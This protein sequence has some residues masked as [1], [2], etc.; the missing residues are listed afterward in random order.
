M[1][2]SNSTDRFNGVL[3]SKAIKV[4]CV[5]ATIANISLA[6]SQ[7]IDG[8]TVVTDDRVLVKDQTN[9]AEN[10]IYD[11]KANA[12]ERAADWDGNRDITTGTLIG[13][14][15]NSNILSLYE[16]TTTGQ[17]TIGTTLVDIAIF[18]T[19]QSGVTI[20]EGTITNAMLRWDGVD[21]YR[22][23]DR[24]RATPNGA[25]LQIYNAALTE[26]MDV[27]YVGT[28][29]LFTTD[30]SAHIFQFDSEVVLNAVDLQMLGGDIKLLDD[31]E[32]QFGTTA[33][34]DF[35]LKWDGAVLDLS[36]PGTTGRTFRLRDG[37]ILQIM[38]DD[39]SKS[40]V[41][42]IFGDDFVW[43]G[44]AGITNFSMSKLERLKLGLLAQSDQVSL[45][46]LE[47]SDAPSDEADY[48]QF[49][50]RD[51]VNQTP[52]F[53][54]DLGVDYEL[55][56]SSSQIDTFR[57]TF[58]DAV[59]TVDPGAGF[60][61]FNNVTPASAIRLSISSTDL[62]GND[63]DDHMGRI[64]DA[65]IV[66]VVDPET[67]A[68]YV[69]FSF[70]SSFDGGGWWLQN[71]I[72]LDGGL[73]P[74]DGQ[75]VLV[76]ITQKPYMDISSLS[77]QGS[78]MAYDSTNQ[79]FVSSL[80][81]GRL[82]QPQVGD[83]R[84][85][86]SDSVLR[87]ES[88]SRIQMNQSLYVDYISN[89][90]AL[91]MGDDGG[92]YSIGTGSTGAKHLDLWS[93]GGTLSV[94]VKGGSTL[95]IAEVADALADI[96]T[97]GQVWVDSDNKALMYTDEAGND[98][99][100]GGALAAK[101]AT[102]HFN[103]QFN[104]S[105]A[106]ADP[107]SGHFSFNNADP[108]LA[109]FMYISET[110]A[111]GNTIDTDLLDLLITGQIVR[112]Q[113]NSDD[114]NRGEML[115]TGNATDFG[116][117][118]RWGVADLPQSGPF[119]Q[120]ANDQACQL[121]HPHKTFIQEGSIVGNN[122][123]M[124]IWND[125]AWYRSGTTL[126]INPA[127]P[128]S[129]GRI[130]STGSASTDPDRSFLFMDGGNSTSCLWFTT[131][132]TDD[133]G[134]FSSHKGT[135]TE[136]YSWNYK[137]AGAAVRIAYMDENYR[138]TI[139]STAGFFMDEKGADHGNLAN[140]GEFWVLNSAPTA[141]MF[142]SSTGVDHNLLSPA[143]SV[144]A[145]GSPLDNQV[146]VFT[147]A[148]DIDSHSGFTWDETKVIII[149][150]VTQALEVHGTSLQIMCF[151][152]VGSGDAADSFGLNK[153]DD[154][155]FLQATDD[156][157]ASTRGIIN[158]DVTDGTVGVG[159]ADGE[160]T[161]N[162]HTRLGDNFELRLGTGD[163]VVI[164]WDTVDLEIRGAAGDQTINFRDGFHI[165][166]WDAADTDWVDIHNNASAIVLTE[167]GLAGIQFPAA[168]TFNLNMID[169]DLIRPILQDYAIESSADDVSGTTVTFSYPDGPVFECDMEAASGN[170]TATLSGGPPS[171][172]YGQITVKMTQDTTVRTL[173]WAGGTF[174][175]AGGA[176]H[177]ITT[178][179]NG[180]SIYTFE[181][182]DGG[183][184]WYGS[185][186]DYS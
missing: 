55:N 47:A 146:A 92:H 168:G 17:I 51:D 13:A 117:Y 116:T 120:P 173:S 68:A 52:M 151:D 160:I 98:F 61:N 26:F 18:F 38:N 76:E 112:Y 144:T 182:W 33:G 152:T 9:A 6:G 147:G 7:L 90:D 46:M 71:V 118:R 113:D 105:T 63:I 57:Y 49:W 171:G 121:Y 58:S 21:T 183:T 34:G 32:I 149:G 139:P 180:F 169:N 15:D 110:D 73:Y 119:G 45:S 129:G 65:W 84:L 136:E 111:D 185:G 44:T 174:R 31:D 142:T 67:L 109:S 62:D 145:S 11:V 162:N 141:P 99:I 157:T 19:G 135:V 30:D 88:A 22:E 28:A 10:G 53:R 164:D 140:K 148:S 124:L 94:R 95:M 3:A 83:T 122:R 150:T 23:T 156:S 81:R 74:L 79:S 24:I 178:T 100:I 107:T 64:V 91:I 181:T 106:A 72:H 154:L 134:F 54:D 97:Y 165:R 89:T 153:Q 103:Y 159:N 29:V 161:L 59:T 50:V 2:V 1:A 78:L 102:N 155:C 35:A 170:V 70:N 101:S 14:Y 104:T 60:L 87:L 172:T 66:K 175:W 132:N 36:S 167:S 42:N 123:E 12:W 186:A 39:E 93:N 130:R 131:G 138:F 77:S 163:D 69:T 115:L 126:L 184:T 128:P 8:V 158:M 56:G 179:S 137:P 5:V 40:A 177:P 166:L 82:D 125:N 127:N 75:E 20:E 86:T 133:E 4:P 80:G 96:L 41:M 16:V 143:G 27:S 85:L 108:S 37:T 114:T 176:A 25:N 48:G 43:Q